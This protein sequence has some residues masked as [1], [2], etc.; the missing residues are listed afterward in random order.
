M[1]EP[2]A[3]SL[4]SGEQNADADHLL[5][6]RIAQR[7]ALAF[8]ILVKKYQAMLVATASRMLG[9]ASEGE[10]FAQLTF[11]RV[12][13]HASNYRPDAKFSTYL[14]TILRHLVMNEARRKKRK[15]HVSSE[16]YA[17]EHPG[18]MPADSAP[19]PASQLDAKETQR[20]IEMAIANL[21]ESQRMAVILR[22]FEHLNYEEIANVLETSVPAVK[23]LLFRA[24][25][26]LREALS[27]YL[28]IA[29]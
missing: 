15:P 23:S 26:Q 21:P 4:P 20:A 3:S 25:C 7:D 13:N 2:M 27:K 5:L 17:S 19:S 14:F 24:R 29:N 22:Q 12:W 1:T 11:L 9:N 18:W 16:A 28:D 6:Q 8:E 10:D